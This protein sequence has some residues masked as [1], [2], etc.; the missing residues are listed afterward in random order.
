MPR[1]IAQAVSSAQSVTS[2]YEELQNS[3]EHCRA[4]HKR[5]GCAYNFTSK[6]ML[7]AGITATAVA[8]VAAAADLL[9]KTVIGAIAMAAAVLTALAAGL[10]WDSQ[11]AEHLK[12]AAG[13][14]NLRDDIRF[15]E[16]EYK[17]SPRPPSERGLF[18]VLTEFRKRKLRYDE[19]AA[20]DALLTSR[21]SK[22][23]EELKSAGR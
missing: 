18:E 4:W 3:V 10:P 7:L 20:V 6:A 5:L 1:P 2:D 15:K 12:L 9:G 16:D 13:Y 8:G 23:G 14:E 11:A 22:R 17:G 21:P 19:R